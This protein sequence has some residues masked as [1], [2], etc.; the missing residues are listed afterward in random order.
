[1]NNSFVNSENLFYKKKVMVIVPHQDDETI[2]CGG[3]LKNLVKLN[4]EIIIVYSTNGDYFVPAKIRMREAI[5]ALSKLGIKEKK[6]IFLGY[7]DQYS[8]END[9]LY[10][11]KDNNIWTSKWQKRETYGP[12][13]LEEYR[14][15]KSRMH[16]KLN[17]ANFIVDIK[18]VITEYLPEI[19]FTIDFD[20]H[21][22]H[23]ALSLGFEKALGIILQENKNYYPLVFKGFAYPTAYFGINDFENENIE[24]T[25]FMTE[26]SSKFKMQNQYYNF[27][28]RIR[29]TI[30]SD[31]LHKLLTKN[32]LFKA[33]KAHKSQLII[34]KANSIINGDQI[35]WQRRTDN[36]LNVAEITT[37]SGNPNYLHDFMYFDCSDIMNGQEKETKY[38]DNYWKPNVD[39][40]KKEITINFF[41]PHK[42]NDIFIIQPC[43]INAVINKV[44][45]LI[46]NKS[47][48]IFEI[49][50]EFKKKINLNL[51]YKVTNIIIRIVDTENLAGISEIEIYEKKSVNL[52]FLKLMIDDNFIYNY[53]YNEEKKIQ[54]YGYNGIQSVFIPYNEVEF[55]LENISI[56]NNII[57]LLDKK[58]KIKVTY[59][60]DKNIYDIVEIRK[61]TTLIKNSTLLIQTINKVM[62]KGIIFYQ[63][64]IRKV[65]KM[66][67][68]NYA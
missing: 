66:L 65:K 54:I 49:G 51:E 62:L 60:K 63:K 56:N 21:P 53:I 14:M 13:K 15:L 5:H 3:I 10:M 59:K 2:L 39:D 35:F 27:N 22:D 45:I 12:G 7:P 26:K 19:I 64:A 58:G 8:K 4:C 41:E 1:M 28:D 34:E 67:V 48:G 6:V 20:S 23:R 17:Y 16:S 44:E 52:Q 50:K 46:N 9:H 30:N 40:N 18:D 36:L 55:E 43:H 29:F 47:I 32:R 57:K 38:L 42:I 11:T 37:S 68:K 31:N 24:S 61:K 25:K 33:L